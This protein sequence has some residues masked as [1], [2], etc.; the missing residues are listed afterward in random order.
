MDL[1]IGILIKLHNMYGGNEPHDEV[2]RHF[3]HN[4]PLLA[5]ECIQV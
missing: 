1:S 4:I 5:Y 3:T 2:Y